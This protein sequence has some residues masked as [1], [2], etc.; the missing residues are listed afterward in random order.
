MSKEKETK[1]TK[2][3]NVIDVVTN[4]DNLESLESTRKSVQSTKKANQSSLD[5]SDLPKKIIIKNIVLKYF[6]VSTLNGTTT[7]SELL[8]TDEKV[9]EFLKL[10]TDEQKKQSNIKP[11][12]G[13][14][15]VDANKL[16][17]KQKFLSEN[18]L[19]AQELLKE[20]QI[21]RNGTKKM[22]KSRRLSDFSNIINGSNNEILLELKGKTL[23]TKAIETFAYKNTAFAN[24]QNDCIFDVSMTDDTIIDNVSQYLNKKKEYIFSTQPME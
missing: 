16:E 21:I 12:F 18:R 20:V 4:F 15:Y 23:Y 17:G 1:E 24:F 19:F 5:F 9:K 14:M 7:I 3:T 8:P 10:E 6:N 13:V 2:E 22:L 11:S